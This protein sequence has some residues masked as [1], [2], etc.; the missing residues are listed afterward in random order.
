MLL[1]FNAVD[2]LDKFCPERQDLVVVGAEVVNV[3]LELIGK[4]LRLTLLTLN[5]SI[6]E[7][8]E[9]AEQKVA[10]VEARSDNNTIGNGEVEGWAVLGHEILE[11]LYALL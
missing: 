1:V 5:D 3:F 10:R 8:A 2:G 6:S 7:W 4:L 9:C 11:L